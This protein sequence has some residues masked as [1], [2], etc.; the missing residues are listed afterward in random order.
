MASDFDLLQLENDEE[1]APSRPLDPAGLRMVEALLFASSEPLSLEELTLRLPEG[2]D[3]LSLLEELQKTYASRGVN[4]VRVA[5]KWFRFRHRR[6]AS[7]ATTRAC[8]SESSR[9]NVP[10]FCRVV[11]FRLRSFGN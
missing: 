5:G 3:V 11:F 6:A 8:R 10:C 1:T 2:T 7:L 9:P 4:L